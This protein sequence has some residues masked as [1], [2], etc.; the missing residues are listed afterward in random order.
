MQPTQKQQDAA[1]AKSEKLTAFL[2]E[3]KMGIKAVLVPTENSL[4]AQIT[5]ID[6]EEYPEETPI[7]E[8][9]AA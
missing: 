6:G 3:N 9:P 4:Q 2:L 8:T 5:I 1:K 7:E